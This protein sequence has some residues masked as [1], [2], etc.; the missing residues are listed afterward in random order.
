MANVTVEKKIITKTVE[1][2][3]PVYNLQLTEE[4]IALVRVSLYDAT[5]NYGL[6]PRFALGAGIRLA[7]N[8]ATGKDITEQRVIVSNLK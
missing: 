5:K 4:E 3:E 8:K 7:I 1:V 6:S 2:E